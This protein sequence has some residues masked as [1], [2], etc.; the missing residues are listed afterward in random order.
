M[1]KVPNYR[2]LFEAEWIV[3]KTYRNILAK[4]IHSTENRRSCQLSAI[5]VIIWGLQRGLVKK[6]L[7]NKITPDINNKART[8]QNCIYKYQII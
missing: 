5:C 4:T 8:S 1:R 6:T 2:S 3:R 7:I